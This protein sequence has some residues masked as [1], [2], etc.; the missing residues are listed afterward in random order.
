LTG[1]GQIKEKRRPL[2]PIKAKGT[3]N[4]LQKVEKRKKKN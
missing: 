4:K 1:P 2:N 3:T